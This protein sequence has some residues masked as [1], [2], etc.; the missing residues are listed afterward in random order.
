[1][2]KE[3]AS[4]MEHTTKKTNNRQEIWHANENNII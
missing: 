2:I 4:N 3:S 1:M